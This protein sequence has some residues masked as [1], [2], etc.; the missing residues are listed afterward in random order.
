MASKPLPA[1]SAE[2]PFGMS[3]R[4]WLPLGLALA[5]LHLVLLQSLGASLTGENR[6]VMDAPLTWTTRT[7]EMPL[8]PPI[9]TAP[10]SSPPI[11]STA[12]PAPEPPALMVQHPIAGEPVPGE[13]SSAVPSGSAPAVALR[14]ASAPEPV[15]TDALQAQSPNVDG[16][17][18]SIRLLY[19]VDANK[20]PY[21]LSS[22]LTWQQDSQQYHASLSVNAFGQSRI[23]SS[24]GQ[25]GRTGLMP[26][27]FSDKFRSEVAAHFNY[28][29]ARVT[30]S[31]NTPDV[32][33][34][35]GA[36]DRLSV[37]IQLAALVASHPLQF[38]PG[39]QISIQ[40]VGPRD[41]DS[42]LFSF[43]AAENLVLPGGNRQGIKVVRLPR[44]QY[45]QKLE[46]WLAPTL[47][48]LP[49][50]IRITEPNGDFIDQLYKGSETVPPS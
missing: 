23:Q 16:V 1:N 17:P 25:I 22:E 34:Q 42:W 27:R 48:Y 20:F 21:R 4:V 44:Q 15:T 39:R 11:F 8:A 14:A 19:Q 18:G 35:V 40:T 38:E 28:D 50:R 24:R 32:V 47:S 5:W 31:A 43:G 9:Q 46:V 2:F 30:F 10:T 13:F 45:D 33:L 49:A 7:I 12:R 29:T 36:Q 26:L 6:V 37:L 3:Y 41:A